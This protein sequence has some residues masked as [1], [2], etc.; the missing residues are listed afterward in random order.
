MNATSDQLTDMNQSLR[1]QLDEAQARQKVKEASSVEL[2]AAIALLLNQIYELRDRAEAH[3][4]K[5]DT[6]AKEY[7]LG[8]G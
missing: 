1:Q 8:L 2:Q 6:T 4:G 5:A 3:E 7:V